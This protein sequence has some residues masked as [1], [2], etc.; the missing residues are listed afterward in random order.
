MSG[1]GR[2]R[3]GRADR[4]ADGPPVKTLA[5]P[6]DERIGTG[7]IAVGRAFGWI[8]VL[9]A[10]YVGITIYTE[11][12]DAVF[13]GVLAPLEP[14]SQRETPLATGLTGAAQ[15]VDE[16]SSPAPPRRVSPTQA[17]RERVTSDL[18]EGARRRGYEAE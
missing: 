18:Q 3:I 6:A 12:I 11:G 14:V 15:G 9:G 16:P 2:R 5:R 13:G 8:L 10:L 1:L 4:A 17:V 7:G